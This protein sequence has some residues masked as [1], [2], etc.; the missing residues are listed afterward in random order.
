MLS[1]QIQELHCKPSQIPLNHSKSTIEMVIENNNIRIGTWNV[2]TL[3]DEAKKFQLADDLDHHNCDILAVQETRYQGTGVETLTSQK[4][5][6]YTLYFTGDDT[7]S[8]GVGIIVKSTT[9]AEFTRINDRICRANIKLKNNRVLVVLSTYAPTQPRCE[10]NPS[11]RESFYTDLD[12]IIKTVSKRSILV[13]AGDFNA[14]TGD[15]YNKYPN[16]MGKFGK[17]HINENGEAL[18]ELASHNELMLTNTKFQQKMSHRTTWEAPYRKYKMKNGEERRNPQRNQI[19]YIMV[20]TENMKQVTNARS[21]QHETTIETDHRLVIADLNT[22]INIYKQSKKNKAFD[23]EKLRNKE[24]QE[25]YAAKVDEL[26]ANNNTNQQNIQEKWDSIVEA[27]QKAAKNILGYKKRQEKSDKK[28]IKDLSEEQKALNNKLNASKNQQKRTEIRKERNRKINQI[29]KLLAEQKHQKILEQTKE[30]EEAQEDSYRMF[31]AIKVL[32]NNEKKKPLLI[33]GEHGLT[34]NEEEQTTIVARHFESVFT[35]EDLEEIQEIPPSEMDPPFTE[36]EVKQAIKTLKNNKSAGADEM[37]AEQLKYGGK[38][39]P[40]KIAEI[41]NETAKTGKHPKELKEGI[42]TPLQKPGK[43]AGPPT[44]LRPIILLTTL[45]KILAIC[46]IRRIGSK[47]NEN[48]P[49]EQA[50]YRAGRSTT[51]HAFTFKILAEKAITSK[52]YK[53]HIS[54]MDM[55]KAFDTVRRHQLIEDLRT[56]LSPAE[57]HLIKIL[58]ENVKLQVK[59]GSNLSKEFETKMGVPQG[60]CLSPILFTLYL[61]K[62]LEEPNTTNKDHTY[63]EHNTEEENTDLPTHLRDHT[64]SAQKDTGLLVKPKY[65]DDI[66]W[67]AANC[68]HR[69]EQE[70]RKTT[71]RLTARGLIVNESKNE[72]YEVSAKSDDK[73]KKCKI[74]G[75]L[76]DTKEDIKR[77]KHL[78]NN[79]TSKLR[80]VF[81]DKKLPNQQ[82]IRV[83]CACIESIFLY[84]SELWTV[85]KTT[86]NQIDSYHRRML[87]NAINIRWPNKISS[88]KLYETTKQ[89]KWSH[90]I[91][92]RRIRWFGH[93]MRLP[94]T[95]PARQ[96]IEEALRPTKKNK[97]GQTKTWLKTVEEDLHRLGLNMTDAMTIAMERKE[98]RG[99]VRNLDALCAQ[100]PQAY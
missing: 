13:V 17:G 56:I 49:I 27:N 44:N 67:A 43:K 9:K 39:I 88:A 68:I 54:L 34:T 19:D 33:Q 62:A 15:G 18:L 83:F 51:E 28:E 37:K 48:I 77:R 26:L 57:L 42:L 90:K 10:K 31:K 20:R 87:R 58:I 24:N 98:W 99:V 85:N 63:H 32:K 71:P 74:L 69:I 91:T 94:P 92:L 95:T 81:E 2:R 61:A 21:Y 59:I 16:N 84:N 89:E 7:R 45:R 72:D 93:A 65:A 82:K 60:D 8:G 100:A 55:S 22:S 38:I 52:D 64:Y 96:A 47:I 40:Q 29:H 5:E 25:Q 79:A 11:L 80:V 76:L 97:G 12:E 3:R 14:K 78:A 23:I 6:N 86:A 70:K 73:W 53:M 75:S 41:L 46:L 50:A 1:Q 30:I 4:G 36:E 66:S 35:T